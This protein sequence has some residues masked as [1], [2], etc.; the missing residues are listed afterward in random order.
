MVHS[1]NNGFFPSDVNEWN[2]DES[3]VSRASEP[4]CIA[5]AQTDSVQDY[6]HKAPYEQAYARGR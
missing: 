1:T 5:L 6:I 3:V 2:H 4:L